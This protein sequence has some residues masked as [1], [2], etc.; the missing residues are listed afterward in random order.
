M[1]SPR[2]THEARTSPHGVSASLGN[3]LA[4]SRNTDEDQ[5]PAG[6]ARVQHTH[7]PA[8]LRPRW[9]LSPTAYASMGTLGS[10]CYAALEVPEVL[11]A[12]ARLDRRPLVVCGVLSAIDAEGCRLHLR[13][14]R[15][16]AG[17]AGGGALLL[18]TEA[19]GVVHL[20]EGTMVKAYGELAVLDDVRGRAAG[21]WLAG[22]RGRN[23]GL[24]H[25][26]VDLSRA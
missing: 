10:P 15:A 7:T 24:T 6:P 8:S 2:S 1:A 21:A 9:A 12:A 22:W 17:A 14:P 25:A 18:N 16:A 20:R 4:P 11:A 13:D 26:Q 3:C 5:G 19:L 23:L